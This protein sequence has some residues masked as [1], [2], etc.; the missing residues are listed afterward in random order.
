MNLKFFCVYFYL[1]RNLFI[2]KIF[3]VSKLN[4]IFFQQVN[5][6]LDFSKLKGL[7]SNYL[8]HWIVLK[9]DRYHH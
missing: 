8:L 5:K 7:K 1:S 6:K 3:V 4:Q 9:M 2:K